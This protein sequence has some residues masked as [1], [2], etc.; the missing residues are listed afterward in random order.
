MKKNTLR[1]RLLGRRNKIKR[2]TVASNS[3]EIL[4]NLFGIKEF[5]SAKKVMFYSA[6]GGEVETAGM[7]EKSLRLRKRVFVPKV[8]G[9][10][11]KGIEI[12]NLENMVLGKYGILEPKTK[13]AGRRVSGLID[14]L[15]VPGVVFD[16]NCNRIGFGRGYF[17]RFLKK[18]KGF[19]IGLAHDFQMVKKIPVSG[20][21]VPMDF[22]ITE[23]HIF[24]RGHRNG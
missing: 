20:S 3:R 7:I 15:V 13:R 1:K 6:F 14:V 18:Q 11:I 19:K 5:L 23:K 4:R 8:V 22:V 2:K 17:D 9:N 12:K 16:V 10:S 24:K 21:D